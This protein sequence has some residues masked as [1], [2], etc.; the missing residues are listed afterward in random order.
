ML[1]LFKKRA[2]AAYRSIT[3]TSNEL[4]AHSGEIND[5]HVSELHGSGRGKAEKKLGILFYSQNQT[6]SNCLMYYFETEIVL[7]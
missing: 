3:Q 2:G 5:F 6:L 4:R 7:H 1:V